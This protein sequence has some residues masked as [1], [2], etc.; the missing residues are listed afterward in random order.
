MTVT[1]LDRPMPSVPAP[2]LDP[3]VALADADAPLRAATSE[4][5]AS[6]SASFGAQLLAALDAASNVL[7]RADGAERNF[8]MG[9]GGLQEMVLERAQADVVLAIAG[10]AASRVAQGLSTLLGMQ[11]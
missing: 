5:A 1:P 4:P 3:D 8:A 7:G 10:V 9:R 11:V 6:G 2:R